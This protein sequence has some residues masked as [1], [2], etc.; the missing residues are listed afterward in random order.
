M[1]AFSTYW[2]A[3]TGSATAS[4]TI[5]LN[6]DR[7]YLVT[8]GL[9]LTEGDDHARVYIAEVCNQVAPDLVT[10]GVRD[11]DG[12]AGLGLVEF[13]SSKAVSVTIKLKTTGG[14]HRGEGVVYEL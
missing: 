7:R 4:V 13:L 5:P 6:P 14:K 11:I 3:V 2:V 10:C 8:G 9:I 12:D 1:N